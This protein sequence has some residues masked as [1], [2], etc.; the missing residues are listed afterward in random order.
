MIGRTNSAAGGVALPSTIAAGETTLYAIVNSTTY[1][2]ASYTSAGAGYNVTALVAGAYRFK[3]CT[4]PRRGSSGGAYARLT[5]NGV[6]VPDSEIVSTANPTSKIIDVAL[7][8]NDVIQVQRYTIDND[9][10]LPYF[11]VSILAADVQ[12]EINKAI[13][14]S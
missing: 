11:T 9:C 3:Y 6:A 5:K 1:R 4:S 8:V 2:S 7:S 12:T 10:Y 13:A 14:I